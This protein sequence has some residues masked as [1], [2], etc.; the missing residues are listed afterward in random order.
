MN[1]YRLA[2]WLAE[3]ATWDSGHV[4]QYLV[5]MERGKRSEAH[6][7]LRSMLKDRR[8]HYLPMDTWVIAMS[9]REA[10]A[11]QHVDGVHGVYKLPANLKISHTLLSRAQQSRL[12]KG[13]REDAERERGGERGREREQKRSAGWAASRRS[14]NSAN[15]KRQFSVLDVLLGRRNETAAQVVEKWCQLLSAGNDEEEKGVGEFNRA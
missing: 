14:T 7:L 1:K 11:A 9:A 4:E 13:D 2:Q 12:H 10:A 15:R 3:E 5:R 8:T 6:A